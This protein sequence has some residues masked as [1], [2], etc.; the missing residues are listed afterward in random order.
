MHTVDYEKIK[1][2][3]F[4]KNVEELKSEDVKEKIK[5]FSDRS[6]YTID[7]ISK[8]IDE[9]K[10]FR[11]FFAKDPIKQNIH[12]NTAM[13]FIKKINGVKEFK[14]Y[15]TNDTFVVNGGIMTG[16]E[17]KNKQIRPKTKSVDFYWKYNNVEYYASHKYTKDEGGGQTHQYNDLIKYITECNNSSRKNTKFLAIADGEFYEGINGKAGTTRIQHLKELA[18]KRTTFAMTINDLEGFMIESND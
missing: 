18:D 12:E 16:N 4:K 11:W 1:N 15:G 5:N 13:G 10:M 7:E 9:D 3:Q 8:K 6:G 17:L 14:K 2:D